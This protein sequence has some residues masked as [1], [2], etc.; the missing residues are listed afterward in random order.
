MKR[1]ILTASAIALT[2]S[3]AS[4][5]VA[6]DAA[7]EP[8][9]R[10][11]NT[12][13]VTARK[14]SE[15]VQDVPLSI[16][17][18]TGEDIEKSGVKGLEELSQQVPAV[19]ISK[20][21]ASD[22]IYVRGIGSGFNSGFEQA[23]GTYVDGVYFGR[24]RATRSSFLDLERLEVLK[25]PQ[26]TFFGNSSIGG[27]LSIVTRDPG[28]EF[29]GNASALYNL[30]YGETDFQAAVDIPV[31][32]T[33]RFRVAGR[34]YDADGYYDETSPGAADLGQ[35][36]DW[37]LRVTG[38]WE[39]TDNFDV[40]VKF[41]TGNSDG[42]GAFAA[43]VI[44]CPVPA[45]LP[46]AGGTRP[47]NF[48]LNQ[49]PVGDPRRNDN[50]LDFRSQA[51]GIEPVESD[52][53]NWNITANYDF[54]DI[55]LT[56]VTGINEFT[57]YTAQDLDQSVGV[58]FQANQQ[59]EFESFSQEFR[60]ASDGDGR[61]NWLAGVYYQDIEVYTADILVPY[62]I[63]PVAGGFG[64]ADGTNTFLGNF[65]QSDT[66]DS[67]TSV[68]VS[69]IYDLTDRFRIDV[70]LRYTEIEKDWVNEN[71]WAVIN[72][73]NAVYQYDTPLTPVSIP[74]GGF[75]TPNAPAT[76]DTLSFDEFLPSF[77][78]EFDVGEDGLLYA[79]YRRGFKA[80]GFETLQRAVA[81]DGSNIND[82]AFGPE[83]V[84]S[85][86][87][88]YKGILMDGRL[89]ANVNLFYSDYTGVQQSV[90]NASTFNFSVE[91]AAASETSGVEIELDY[92]VTDNFEVRFNTTLMD[93]KFSDFIGACN[94]FQ[95]QTG[96]CPNALGATGAQDLSGH[97]TTFAPGY[98]G[99]L[100]AIYNTDIGD[101]GLEID[102]NL[103]FTDSYFIQSDFD[104]AT[105]VDAHEKFDLRVTLLPPAAQ[106]FD[107][108]LSLVGKNLTDE[109]TAFFCNDLPASPGSYRCSLNPPRS[110]SLQASVNF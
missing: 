74:F 92:D 15:S 14:K 38:L 70:G 19:N 65:T 94:E 93:A 25:G 29:G 56:S 45:P 8:E 41:A 30:E 96:T 18:T 62:F 1:T 2:A 32:D 47:C 63:P 80:G 5:A 44:N 73:P 88:G 28:T 90:L 35:Y 72:D 87:A 61:L 27:A 40:R 51:S 17:V 79:N 83:E 12:V 82:F 68:F 57:A 54:G 67:T 20:G 52:Y 103:F 10:T 37:G 24:S 16:S 91:N 55:V 60:L 102:G 59:D 13:T 46:G 110:V 33:L 36:D 98:S 22:Q 78:L 31:S 48:N 23:V 77:G 95:N 71:F 84:D 58:N 6:Q 43:D 53:D 75:A 100:R 107:W 49:F 89:R 105:E 85:F 99:N 106:N 3:L 86:E 97:E 21:G 7:E 9:A 104:P 81:A 109:E 26:T 108:E 39:P 50:A 4:Y 34:K 66:E 11:L 101:W 42:N 69:G 76:A 64:V